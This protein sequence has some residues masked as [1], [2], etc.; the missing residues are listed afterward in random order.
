MSNQSQS[1]FHA[2]TICCVR[3]N[4]SVAIAGDGQVTLG[5]AIVVKNNAKKIRKL[6]NGK[7]IAGFAGSATDGLTLLE[8]L[9]HS[10]E[11]TDGNLEKACIV[12]AK[13]WRSDKILRHLDAMMI[14]A[15]KNYT[16]LVSGNGDVL[17]PEHD[18]VAIGSGGQY[19]YSAAL[20]LLQTNSQLNS[21]EIAK[22]SLEIAG[23][24]C[25]FTNLN[26][27]TEVLS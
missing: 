4:D 21:L 15:D 23:Q 5:Q 27:T 1:L 10:L 12:L 11:K 24:I 26:I 9:E 19:A 16:F 2:T 6:A 14:V 22:K 17:A 20:A 7:V 25:V 3:K 18:A 8:K 13:I